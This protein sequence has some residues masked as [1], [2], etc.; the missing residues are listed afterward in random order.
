MAKYNS[1]GYEDSNQ[2]GKDNK[3][4]I[5]LLLLVVVGVYFFYYAPSGSVP[6][7]IPS[8]ETRVVSHNVD[9]SEDT[10][11]INTMVMQSEVSAQQIEDWGIYATYGEYGDIGY[12]EKNACGYE[13]YGYPTYLGTQ[14]E[15]ETCADAL[16]DKQDIECITSPPA[17]YEGTI[18]L[19]TKTSTPTLTCCVADGT[20]HWRP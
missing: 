8:T 13:N 10:E 2:S 4:L 1:F 12:P 18:N 14:K 17:K 16:S 19:L 11:D 6:D 9:V 3:M 20:C 5:G 7:I 15:G